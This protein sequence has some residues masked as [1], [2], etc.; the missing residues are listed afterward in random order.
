MTEQPKKDSGNL[1]FGMIIAV[2][3]YAW[4]VF[5]SLISKSIKTHIPCK[6]TNHPSIHK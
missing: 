1:S 3:L 2:P 6:H 5:D 4:Y